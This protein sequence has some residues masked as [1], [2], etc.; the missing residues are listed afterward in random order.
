[1]SDLSSQIKVAG[2]PSVPATPKVPYSGKQPSSS[3]IGGGLVALVV[4]MIVAGWCAPPGSNLVIILALILV[5]MLILGVAITKR[6]LGILINERNLV[7]LSRL[8]MALW[9]CVVLAAYFSFAMAR[10]KS[11]TPD[12]LRIQIDWHLWALM[13]ISTASLVGTPLLLTG[14]KDKEPDP[15]VMAQA[16][17]LVDEP[18]ESIEANREGTLYANA[19]MADARITDMFQGDELKNTAHIDFAKVQMFYFTIIAAV[20]FLVMVFRQITTQTADLGQLPVLPDGL[21]AILG[22]SNAGYLT[23]KSVD[24]TKLKS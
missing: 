6:P 18:E 5:A 10:V 24:H 3:G 16:S 7:S 23:S 9:T 14:K 21:I 15:A 13:G 2:T 19:T 17:Q 8:Q 1:M 20:S 22:I 12:P 11:S 4:L